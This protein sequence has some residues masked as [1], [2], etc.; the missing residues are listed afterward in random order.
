LRRKQTLASTFFQSSLHSFEL[1]MKG[2]Y[3][4]AYRR[5]VKV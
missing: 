3:K 5:I 2:F 4:V 1:Q